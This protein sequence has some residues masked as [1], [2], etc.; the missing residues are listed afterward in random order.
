MGA[1]I[2][3]IGIAFVLRAKIAP[4]ELEFW[5]FYGVRC[6]EIKTQGLHRIDRSNKG[7]F[8]SVS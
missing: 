4:C 8:P 2:T 7:L 1:Q 5:K 6:S 3:E